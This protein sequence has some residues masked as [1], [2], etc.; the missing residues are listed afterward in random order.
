MKVKSENGQ[1]FWRWLMLPLILLTKSKAF[2]SAL[3]AFKAVKALKPMVTMATMALSAFV[4]SF[5]WGIWFAIGFVIML[6]IHEMGHVIAM[7]IKKLPTSGPVFIPMLGAVIF[8]PEFKGKQTEAFV[9]Y[10][11][12]LLGGIAAV[13]LFIIWAILPVQYELLLVLSYIAAI[14]N[15]FNL[16]PIRPLDG[17]RV[18]QVIGG[19]FKWIGFALL[20]IITIVVHQPHILLIWLI[21]ISD[22]R[23]NSKFKLVTGFACQAIMMILM[24]TGFSTQP[25]W[26][27]LMDIVLATMINL[28]IWAG[29]QRLIEEGMESEEEEV[30]NPSV[31]VKWL[32][33]Y[34]LLIAGLIGVM[35]LQIPHLP[36]EIQPQH[37][38]E[39]TIQTE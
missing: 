24:F 36:K 2:L 1:S 28:G 29:Y 22:L 37:E 5:M 21:V 11:G 12:P 30:I 17:G 7:K 3:K 13:L 27:N 6:F 8:A 31:Q 39:E 15:L 10:G 18:T 9:G 26:L 25:M 14:V 16:V 34:L 33:Y 4:Y 19:W 32:A 20:L 38:V 35:S 23:V